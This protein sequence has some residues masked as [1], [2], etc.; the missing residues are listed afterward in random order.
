MRFDLLFGCGPKAGRHFGVSFVG[1][2]FTAETG[3]VQ[4]N[5]ADLSTSA[6][7]KID[8]GLINRG[9]DEAR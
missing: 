6:V 9:D 5:C 2:V 1:A 3:L 8:N 4:K 7:V